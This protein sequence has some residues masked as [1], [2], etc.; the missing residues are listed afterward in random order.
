MKIII[1]GAGPRG[2]AC[3]LLAHLDQHDV[4]IIDPQPLH[5]WSDKYLIPDI[6]MRSPITFDLV[7]YLD[8]DDV[9]EWSLSAFTHHPRPPIDQEGIESSDIFPNRRIFLAYLDQVLDRLLDRGVKLIR[10]SV[11]RFDKEWVRLSDDDIVRGD[12][13]ILAP[14]PSNVGKL[15]H[16]IDKTSLIHKIVSHTYVLNNPIVNRRIAI[17]GSGQSAAEFVV[18]LTKLG[19]DVTWVT[20]KTARI[21][22]Y[23]VPSYKDWYSKSGLGSYYREQLLDTSLRLGYLSVVR[24]WQPS[25]TP[26]IKDELDRLSIKPI[27]VDEFSMARDIADRSDH[28]L[29]CTGFKTNL[30]AI[31][32]SEDI[33]R[34]PAFPH[35]PLLNEFRC[36]NGVYV[37]GLLAQGFDGPRQGSIVSAALTAQSI[38]GDIVNVQ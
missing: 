5:T 19:N 7:S 9:F 24:E 31:P 20:D 26:Y 14:G 32:Y 36:S 16:W 6:R 22:Q 25:I 37:T 12:A 33:T 13:V 28:L 34:D 27:R 8:R 23:P 15:P 10:K 35:L 11:I 2:L 18:Y 29:I 38:L 1:I 3:A 4:T 30:D 17:I 21:N